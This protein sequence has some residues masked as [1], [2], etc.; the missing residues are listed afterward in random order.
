M[1]PVP[2]AGIDVHGGCAPWV[3]WKQNGENVLFKETKL[4]DVPTF[5]FFFFTVRVIIFTRACD[6]LE[7]KM[8]L[9]GGRL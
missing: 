8:I 2:A 5:F 9:L 6:R 7:S 3:L 1:Q 4:R